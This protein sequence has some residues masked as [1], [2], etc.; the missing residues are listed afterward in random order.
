V[1]DRRQLD[2]FA[3]AEPAPPREPA[4]EALARRLPPHVRFGTSS[5][6]FPGWAGIVY[7]RRYAS[8][9]AFTRESLAEYARHPL[10][11][12]VGVDRSYYA[13]VSRAEL[14]EYARAV[15]EG[16][17]L[18]QKVWSEIATRVFP[19]HPR[20]K[21]RAGRANARFLDAELFLEAQVVPSVEGLG[22][23]IGPFILE[24]PPAPGPADE[25][26]FTEALGRFLAALSPDLRIAVEL[27]DARL[28]TSR[29]LDV[30][31]VHG[32]THCY[33]LWTRMPSIG[34]QLDRE[35]SMAGPFVV[36]RLM[37]PRGKRYEDMRDAFAPFDRIVAPEPEMRA[38][39]ARLVAMA[40]ERGFETFVLVNNKAEGSSP[41]TVRALAEKVAR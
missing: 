14:E 30:L 10:F 33:N 8:D 1:S 41:L 24:I 11:R 22:D 2:L 35:G 12:T 16:F 37:I 26:G 40:G 23:R 5:W 28:F 20:E 21:D 19:D 9:R 32:A 13:P 7:H 17:Q 3:E 25:R 38:D 39:V 36:A 34:A 18:C 29:Y 6:T 27:R 15:P 4:L 31:R